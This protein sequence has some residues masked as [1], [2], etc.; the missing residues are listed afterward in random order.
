M[1]FK[2]KVEPQD[3]STKIEKFLASKI[4]SLSQIHIARLIKE[5][6]CEID[7]ETALFKQ[8][9]KQGNEICFQVEEIIPN[10][11]TPE[12]IPLEIVYEDETILIVVKPSGMLVHPTVSV[13]TGTLLNALAYYVNRIRD[14]TNFIRP[15]LVHRLDRNTSGL[16][17]ITKT[18]EALSFLMSHFR[19]KLVRKIYLAIVEGNVA[20]DEM[21]IVAPIGRDET[22]KPKWNVRENGK[23]SETRLR[24]LERKENI[25]LVELQPITGR[26]NQLRIHCSHICHPIVGDDLHGGKIHSR[27]CL[28]AALLEFYHPVTNERISFS[29]LLPDEI[30]DLL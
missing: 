18:S 29:S 26:T 16:M 3:D 27:L 28:H 15:G 12:N 11:M 8:R 30:A 6:A 2:Y 7:G 22:Q 14:E 17:V 21:T 25:T 24:V 4:S 13:K 20:Q 5:G 19:R 10:S 9:I 23:E 1:L